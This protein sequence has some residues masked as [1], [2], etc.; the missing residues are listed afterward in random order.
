VNLPNA[1]SL[2]RLLAVPVTVWLM[3]ESRWAWALGMFV[4][5]GVSDAID[6]WLARK[7][8]ARTTLGHYL[9][10]MADKVL[11]VAVFVTLAFKGA[12]PTWL[13]L[14]IVTRDL[15]LV[16]GTLL[17][18]VVGQPIKMDPLP[19]SK[20]NTVTQIVLAG[21]VLL[22]LASGM[23]PELVMQGLT[24]AVVGTTLLSGAGY[25]RALARGQ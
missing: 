20:L 5:A 14:L 9:D 25:V 11:L 8:D 3:L 2:G 19:I 22:Q 7:M 24:A 16:G 4:A 13:V 6:G 1:I 18:Y 23:V 15:L 12:V 10:P 21:M 17:L